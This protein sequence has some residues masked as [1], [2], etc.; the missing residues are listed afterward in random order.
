MSRFLLPP[1]VFFSA[2]SSLGVELAIVRLGAPYVGQSLLPWSAAIAS[3]LLGL[4]GGHVLGGIVSGAATTVR[5]ARLRLAVVWLLAG[6]AAAAM[7]LS[8]HV[9]IDAMPAGQ[10]FDSGAV[11]AIAALACP[12]SLAAG[13]VAPLAVRVAVLTPDLRLPRMVGSIYAAS[14]A[15]SVLGT[16]AAGFVLLERIGASGLASVV[17]G[18][19]IALGIGALPWRSFSIRQAAGAAAAAAVAVA[20]AFLLATPGPCLLESRYTCIR[21]FD[22]NLGGH[23]LRF[24]VLDEGVH[25]ASDRDDA[26]RLH[27]GYAGLADRLA[28]AA[29]AR[30]AAPRALVIGGGGATLPRAWAADPAQAAVTVIELDPMVAVVAEEAMWAGGH[31]ALTTVIGDGRAVVRALPSSETFAVVLMDAYRTRSVPP[32]LVTR[33][34][35]RMIAARMTA[36]GVFLSNV[37]DRSGTPLLALSIARTLADSFPVVDIWA[38][39]SSPDDTTNY[40][41]AAWKNEA[42]AHRSDVEAVRASVLEAGDTVRTREVVWRRVDAAA[43]DRMWPRACVMTLTDDRAPVDRLL[44]GRPPPRCERPS[45]SRARASRDV[46]GASAAAP[47]NGG[48]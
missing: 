38:P 33:E 1:A 47:S 32:H 4:T 36:Q 5:Q 7:P 46:P 34:F 6:L 42:A 45:A 8:L 17:A 30:V 27:L 15:G 48:L 14:A 35:G 21:L 26:R 22:E 20:A 19:W 43:A 11:L 31:P 9:V 39:A 3:V 12:P 13:L 29:F 2:A 25:S 44:A 28:R 40:V 37:I 41:V 23:M 16:A 10:D 24:M 18:I